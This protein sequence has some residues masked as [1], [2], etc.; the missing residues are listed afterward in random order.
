[1]NVMQSVKL[2]KVTA[3]MG[4]GASGQALENAFKLLETLTGSTPVKTKA[5][6]RE[7]AF[8][9]RKG[10]EVGVKVTLRGE[11]ARQFLSKALKARENLVPARGIDGAGNV[12]FG[13]KEYI[14]F[15]GAKYD[16]NIGMIGFDVCVTLSKAGRRIS[17]RRIAPRRMPAKQWVNRG[18]ARE[19][20]E[21]EFGAVFEEEEQ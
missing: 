1:M 14:D 18:E 15:P 5:R 3:N 11:K 12:A 9:L 2:D 7:P 17:R 21:K 20:M 13:V 6:R 4:V 16:P 19:F 10:D 8:K